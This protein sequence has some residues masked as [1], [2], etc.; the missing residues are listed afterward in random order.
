[1]ALIDL[2]AKNEPPPEPEESEANKSARKFYEGC[3]A[4]RPQSQP[5]EK[6]EISNE[7]ALG[8]SWTGSDFVW[9]SELPI[10]I[11]R[12]LQNAHT[13]GTFSQSLNHW[14]KVLDEKGVLDK[15]Y[16]KKLKEYQKE[17]TGN[18]HNDQPVLDKTIALLGELRTSKVESS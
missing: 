17:I 9:I 6:I 13:L 4:Y 8:T 1:M 5:D 12:K 7:P 11:T 15:T 3:P 10:H 14:V 2:Y 18:F 16:V